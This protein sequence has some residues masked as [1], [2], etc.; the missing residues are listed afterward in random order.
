MKAEKMRVPHE[1]LYRQYETS[2]F[3]IH[4]P[5]LGGGLRPGGAGGA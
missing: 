2:K 5:G 3:H 1:L 4:S